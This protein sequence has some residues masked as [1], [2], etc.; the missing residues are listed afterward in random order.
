MWLLS[1]STYGILIDLSKTD[2]IYKDIENSFENSWFIN[3]SINNEKATILGEYTTEQKVDE[4]I[5]KLREDIKSQNKRIF[6]FPE[7]SEIQIENKRKEYNIIEAVKQMIK[8]DKTIVNVKTGESFCKRPIT[9]NE[10]IYTRETDID[11]HENILDISED[12]FSVDDIMAKYY[13][14][15]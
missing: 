5:K 10:I 4:V 2:F 6:V 11:R 8:N 14:E 15:D 1:Q 9:V 3:A 7:D 13:I 12:I